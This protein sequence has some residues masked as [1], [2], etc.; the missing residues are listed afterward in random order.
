MK[1][2]A[3]VLTAYRDATDSAVNIR[4]PALNQFT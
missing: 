1:D 4:R 3:E 2:A